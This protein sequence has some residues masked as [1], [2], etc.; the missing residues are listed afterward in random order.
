[1][2]SLVIKNPH[3]EE[4]FQNFR[5]DAAADTTI[6][7]LKTRLTERYP[8]SPSVFS[9]TLIHG[10]RIVKNDSTLA[11]VISKHHGDGPKTFH[12]IVKNMAAAAA[13][14]RGRIVPVPARRPDDPVFSSSVPT[15]GAELT[16]VQSAPAIGGSHTVQARN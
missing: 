16:Q 5:M 11:E 15:G 4:A 14:Q 10:G 13:E 1:M 2:L 9:Q 3:M 8:T 7:E 6:L 12:L